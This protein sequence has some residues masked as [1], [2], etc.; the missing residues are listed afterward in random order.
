[1]KKNLLRN[2]YTKNVN[3]NMRK[4]SG[5]VDKPDTDN[6]FSND[7]LSLFKKRLLLKFSIGGNT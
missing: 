3:R 5:K 2:N 1:M 7:I 6:R 4:I